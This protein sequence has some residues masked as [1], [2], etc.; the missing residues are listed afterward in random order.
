MLSLHRLRMLAE[1][2]RLGTLSEVARAMSYSPSAV[3]Q[4]LAVLEKEAGV[5]LLERVGR[6]VRLTDA[7]LGLVDHADA[8][9]E[10]LERAEA[11]LAATRPDVSGTLRVASFQSPLMSIAPPALTWL[12][13]QHPALEVTITQR[14]QPEA[15]EGLL[16][17]E[18]DVI[19]GEEFPGVHDPVPEGADREHL[20]DDPLLLVLPADGP[21][22]DPASL[23]DLAQAPWAL[24]PAPSSTG[25]WARSA[26]RAAGFEPRVRFDTPDPLLQAHLVR[27]GHAAALIPAL[28]AGQH[29]GGTVLRRMPGDP[30]RRVSTAVRAGRADHPAIRAFRTALQVAARAEAPPVGP[31]EIPL[32]GTS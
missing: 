16:A 10:R 1:L 20:L 23:A 11:E 7:A 31:R 14:E 28:I 15:Y 30:R 3:S 6:G 12:A 2:H 27:S 32:T 9:L 19:L 22:S 24:D 17:H 13:E 5:P 21:W 18:F 8:I 26:L 29:L 25:Q 4:Q